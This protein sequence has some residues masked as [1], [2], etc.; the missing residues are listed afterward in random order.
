MF[1]LTVKS[2]ADKRN[3]PVVW[4]SQVL[5]QGGWGCGDK[6]GK[7]KEGAAEYSQAKCNTW[8]GA[9]RTL[10]T[11]QWSALIWQDKRSPDKHFEQVVAAQQRLRAKLE[12]YAKLQ[13][14]LL[15][16]KELYTW[17]CPMTIQ[18]LFE[19]TP[20]LNNNLEYWCRD[21]FVDCDFYDG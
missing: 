2:E 7:G 12:D 10:N 13:H 17:Y 18:P 8:G 15:A 5:L 3:D 19:H 4:R 6:E 11:S 1:Q 21:D 14:D 16:P 9:I 20:V